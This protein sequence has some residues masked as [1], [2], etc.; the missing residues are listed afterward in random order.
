MQVNGPEG[1]PGWDSVDWGQAEENVRRLRRRIFA[2][3]QAGDLK[4]VRSLQKLMLRSR[5]SALV[6]V[7]RVTEINAGRKTA[8][9]DGRIVLAGWEKADM[10]AWLQHGAAGW[11]PL[12]VRRVY[13]PK[14]NGR[15]RGLGIPVI[16]DR[17]LQALAA[18]A[19]EPEWEARFEP[20]SYG[21]RP[22]RGCHD[23][24]VAIH[25]SASRQDARRLWVLD[26]DLEAA[27]DRLSHD[28]ILRSL[29]TFPARG[30]VRRWLRAGVMEDGRVTLTRE[31]VP[32]G[33]V[34]S[35]VIM[36]V[37]LHGM[38]Q[39]A[40]VRYWEGGA[41]LRAVPG[42]PVLV[43]YADD[44]AVLCATRA[45]AEQ[46]KEQLAGWL[47]PR[48]LAFSEAKTR[49]VHLSQGFDFLGFSIRRYPNGKLLT[50][51]GKEAMRRIRER[52]SNEAIAMR[53][54]NA[55]ALIARLNPIITGWAAYYRI[56][57]S[58]HAYGTLDAH[59]W[60]LAWKW[61]NFSHPNK[62][63]RWIITRHFGKF[64]PA[65]QDKWVLGSRETGFYLRKFAWTKIVRH[66][67]AAGR[68]SPDDPALTGYWQQRR[69][70]DRLPVDPAT[71]HLLRRQRGRCPLCRGLLLHADRQPQSP[72]E[73][74]QWHTVT[75]K[76]I[77]KHAIDSVTDLGTPDGRVAYHLI[78]AHCRR[79]IGSGT[80]PAL[81]PGLQPLRAC[82]SRAARKAGTAGSEGTPARQRAGVTRR[83]F[84]VHHPEESRLPQRLRRPGRAG[85]YPACLR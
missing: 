29:G 3:S 34:I 10:A 16:A 71:W 32:Q 15:R 27:F 33:G 31:G 8:G 19:L 12:P 85:P 17:A 5:S 72:E 4:K 39:A 36:N 26:A 37:A 45:Q 20:R 6:S 73:W 11:R 46:V 79:R 77:R 2:A 68:A 41:T 56:G 47:E 76:A 74:Q 23:A 42:T 59:L 13:V 61:A 69:R 38:E 62:P 50:K 28:H 57:V 63:R 44:L 21:F 35:P 66:R 65:R 24:I 82:L 53:G 25:T 40:G 83:D 43:R 18:S 48:G 55:D 54:A 60:R 51:P 14:S 58:K 7:R 64:N 75:R 30:L 84:P 78:H 52:L 1:D 22:G 67:M 70:R 9:V 80:S 81:L 49:I